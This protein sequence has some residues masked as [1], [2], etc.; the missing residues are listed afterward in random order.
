MSG[1]TRIV[2]VTFVV[3]MLAYIAPLPVLPGLLP[4]MLLTQGGATRQIAQE[5][6]TDLEQAG[7]NDAVYAYS[8]RANSGLAYFS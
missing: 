3:T 5:I 1:G 2:V 8:Y 6:M 4:L 7:K